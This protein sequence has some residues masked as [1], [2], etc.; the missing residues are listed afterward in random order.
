MGVGPS[1]IDATPC[2]LDFLA[3]ALFFIVGM[4][5]MAFIERRTLYVEGDADKPHTDHAS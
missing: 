5:L 2:A 4:M 1:P 3:D